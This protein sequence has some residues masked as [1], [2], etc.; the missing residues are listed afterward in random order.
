MEKKGILDQPLHLVTPLMWS[1]PLTE[2]NGM[3][4]WLKLENAQNAGSY[5]IRGLGLLC[6]HAVKNGCTQFVS[7]SGGN[8]GIAASYAAKKLGI[9]ITVCVPKI[10]PE[11]MIQKIRHTATNVEVIGDT[12]DD[13]NIR[14]IELAKQP[15]AVLIHPFD[16]PDIWKGHSTI[17]DEILEQLNGVKPDVVIVAVGGGGLFS[18]LME[19]FQRHGMTDVTFLAMETEGAKSFYI[20]KESGQWLHLDKIDTIAKTLGCKQ[21]CKNAFEWILKYKNIVS[22]TCTDKEAVE[23]ALNFAD[24]HRFLVSPSAGA[25]LVPVYTGLITKLQAEGQL[26]KGKLNVVSIVCGGNEVNLK[27]VDH[28]KELF[29]LK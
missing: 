16:H 10:T 6:Q 28:W 3:N 25:A 4:I 24:D 12:W 26:P 20:C 8:A 27:E 1:P 11:F 14:A 13:A 29:H 21:I 22:R 7:S 9:P 19:G 17:V 18:G 5:K 15:G 23:A 2:S